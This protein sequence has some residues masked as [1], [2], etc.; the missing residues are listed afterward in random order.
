MTRIMGTITGN[1]YLDPSL[2]NYLLHGL[3]PGGFLC[4]VLC[5]DLYVAVARA[6]AFN[7]PRISEIVS[8]IMEVFPE[9]AYGSPR[10]YRAWLDDEDGRRSNYK[11]IVEQRHLLKKIK[12]SEHEKA[13]DPP[14]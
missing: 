9:E 8:D 12:N 13:N 6:D 4:S 2:E 1:S 11:K 5:N 3:E 14:F 7:R 10:L